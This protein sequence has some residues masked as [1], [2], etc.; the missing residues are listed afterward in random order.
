MSGN[1]AV[2][3]GAGDLGAIKQH[4]RGLGYAVASFFL[5]AD[6]YGS[7]QSRERVYI[8]GALVQAGPCARGVCAPPVV[9]ADPDPPDSAKDWSLPLDSFLFVPEHP[10]V[11]DW[12][13]AR[14]RTKDRRPTATRK[15]STA[16][17]G[18]DHLQ[19]YQS[20][21]LPWPPVFD[22]A[23]SKASAH[24]VASKKQRGG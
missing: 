20:I 4:C 17:F 22:E 21:D 7:P 23:F 10:E 5:R 2:G 1:L 24:L 8:I 3:K 13:D 9:R 15:G 6:D 16:D 14:Q 12:L 11:Q 19:A 18:V